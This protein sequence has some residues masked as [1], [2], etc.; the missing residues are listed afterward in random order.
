M[1]QQNAGLFSVIDG[2]ATSRDSAAIRGAD[3]LIYSCMRNPAGSLVLL[4][5]EDPSLG[6]YDDAAPDLVE[7]Q[8]TLH[9]AQVT[10]M[11]VGL[12]TNSTNAALVAAMQ[13]VDAVI[14][15][16]RIGDQGRFK[17]RY[18]NRRSVMSYALNID[19]LASGY[20][21]LDHQ[22]M[23]TFKNAIDRIMLEAARITV[24]CPLGTRFEGGP[25]D[26]LLR[27]REVVVGRFPMGI[28]RP[29]LNDDFF[30]HVVLARY[31]TPTGSR[32]Y[33]PDALALRVPVNAHFEGNHITKFTGPADVVAEVEAHYRQIANSFDLEAWQID[34]W[35]AGIHPLMSY[36]MPA[37]QD[38]VPWSNVGF[39]HPRM[40]HFH[41]CG[42]G[43]PGEVTWIVIDP[44]IT[45]DGVA[46]WE[47][48]HLHP[49]RFAAT[50]EILDMAPDFAA[51]FR[52]QNR[53][54]GLDAGQNA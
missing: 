24:T 14:F 22:M 5:C 51:A 37:S 23:V 53:Q 42:S 15:F 9:G 52:Q 27:G 20:G 46:L 38:P 43:P 4:V 32:V 50:K 45:I 16:A 18:A 21:T 2:D 34:S 3:N 44:T 17:P 10:R 8:L 7:K 13:A 33:D 12:P 28:P 54:I 11:K 25:G 35:H 19:M 41:T 1:N 29:I 40:L 6:W 49:E 48:G 47:N 31:L 39:Q 36:D 26:S 30:G